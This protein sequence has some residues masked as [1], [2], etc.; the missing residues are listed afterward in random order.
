MMVRTLKQRLPDGQVVDVPVRISE[1]RKSSPDWSCT[2]SIEWPSA[3]VE[4]TV[5]G[6]D[7]VQAAFLGLQMAGI[8]VYTSEQHKDGRLFWERP[9]GGYGFPVPQG[10]RDMLE[11]DDLKQI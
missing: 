3:R 5:A 7:S 6:L 8:L 9:R 1:P 11:G 2:V 4:R 10:L